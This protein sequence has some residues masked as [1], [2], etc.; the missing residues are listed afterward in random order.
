MTGLEVSTPAPC[1]VAPTPAGPGELPDVLGGRYRIERL[2]GA[3]GM[4][5]VYRARDLLQEQFGDP[6]PYIALKLLSEAFTPSPDAGALLFNEFALIRHLRHPNVL[7]MYSFNVDTVHQR[8]Y[9]VMELLRGPTLDRLLC[10]HPLGLPWQ[11]WRDI[12]LPLLDAMAHAHGRGVLHGDI[13]PSNV[14][15]SDDGVRLFD[16]GLGQAETSTLEGLAPVSRSRLNAWTP[17]YAAAE[18]LEGQPLTR[19]ADVYALGCLLY[20]LASGKHPYNRMLATEAR[21]QHTPSLLKPP[22]NLPPHLWPAL[23]TALALDPAKR[24]ITVEQ[25]LKAA[26]RAPNWRQRLMQ[27]RP[28][29]PGH[30]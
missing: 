13:K 22:Q 4:G 8:V 3:G 17:G 18:I 9:L 27:W 21:A 19:A 14:L 2:L 25:L 7:R 23:R 24:T 15:L 29:K 6:Q 26:S 20:E 11:Q 28:R 12:A 10:E 16:F 5:T 30:A 1:A